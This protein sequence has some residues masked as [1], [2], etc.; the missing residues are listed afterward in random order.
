ML[1]KKGVLRN[2]AIFTGKHLCQSPF[3]LIKLQASACN[4]IKKE[5][6]AQLFS[7]KFCEIS[8]NACSCRTLPVAI[9]GKCDLFRLVNIYKQMKFYEYSQTFIMEVSLYFFIV[10]VSEKTSIP[11]SSECC[12]SAKVDCSITSNLGWRLTLKKSCIIRIEIK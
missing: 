6:L 5:N 11:L 7:W 9:F 2:F 1:C 3:F 10:Q 12:I 8:K 4:F